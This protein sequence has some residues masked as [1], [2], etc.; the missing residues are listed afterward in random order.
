M[1]LACMKYE[2][3]Y[4]NKYPKYKDC[5]SWVTMVRM[6]AVESEFNRNPKQGAHGE[7]GAPQICEYSIEKNGTK[8]QTL[9]LLL[10]SIGKRKSSYVS[11]IL[12]YREDVDTQINAMY[13][14]F[15]SKLKDTD[16]SVKKA[17]V[18]YNSYYAVPELSPYWYRYQKFSMLASGWITEA[19]KRTKQ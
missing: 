13:Q 11:T 4:K 1:I 18:A 8:T 16:G 3:V 14:H 17:I 15:T 10:C 9:Y 7:L 2:K 6:L 12:W 5:Y 19:K